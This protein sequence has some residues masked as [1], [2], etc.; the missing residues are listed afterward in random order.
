[1]RFNSGLS[2]LL[3]NFV[4]KTRINST[5]V[6]SGP[7]ILFGSLLVA[8]LT[9][10]T[11]P[12]NS[13][14]GFL[15]LVQTPRILFV[16]KNKIVHY[17][18]EK[19]DSSYIVVVMNNQ[20]IKI[21][22]R[23]AYQKS[24]IEYCKKMR[25]MIVE[26]VNKNPDQ[27]VSR[28]AQIESINIFKY[29]ELQRV[30]MSIQA[31]TGTKN[32]EEKHWS[33]I[34]EKEGLQ[35]FLKRQGHDGLFLLATGNLEGNKANLHAYNS[36]RS[37]KKKL[38]KIMTPVH[39][40]ESE[41]L[42]SQFLSKSIGTPNSPLLVYFSKEGEQNIHQAKIK[43]KKYMLLGIKHQIIHQKQQ[44]AVVV[45]K[46]PKLL[47][48]GMQNDKL[49]GFKNDFQ[50]IYEFLYTETNY[51]NI[52]DS[53]MGSAIHFKKE[54]LKFW[55][56]NSMMME[57]VSI[58]QVDTQ[59]GFQK[60]EDHLSPRIPIIVDP[61]DKNQSIEVFSLA[62]SA[63]SSLRPTLSVNILSSNPEQTMRDIHNL[64]LN[65]PLL[66]DHCL[67]IVFLNS[68]MSHLLPHLNELHSPWTLY[69]LKSQFNSSYRKNFIC[70]PQ[71]LHQDVQELVQQFKNQ[72]NLDV[73]EY[74]WDQFKSL[75][76]LTSKMYKTP[77]Q[78]MTQ[79]C[80]HGNKN[81]SQFLEV[82]KFL[83]ELYSK[84]TKTDMTMMQSP[85]IP[86][87]LDE[88]QLSSVNIV[89]E[90]WNSLDIID[91]KNSTNSEETTGIIPKRVVIQLED[92]D[93]E[94]G[95]DTLRAKIDQFI[96]ENTN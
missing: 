69:D 33:E 46:D 42:F 28:E 27:K 71:S 34:K 37:I 63:N 5:L 58:D 81:S 36:R 22:D 30:R 77:S 15:D 47:D 9:L 32:K 80:L 20:N 62:H 51:M 60:V 90:K 4:L 93:L 10:R 16:P 25:E 29:S 59:S 21:K 38:R 48:L 88:R 91:I 70:S 78:E 26:K 55:A 68:S 1:M 74:Q 18:M 65:F 14:C 56:T 12:A 76:S 31:T 87:F 96:S 19:D 23:T 66:K 75:T 40:L 49:Y 94:K 3:Q 86:Y 54:L 7:K 64:G 43:L 72:E 79:I 35:I 73:V 44:A 2:R 13:K 39:V 84:N 89:L 67:P 6:K 52:Q 41:E 8:G 83:L 61:R 45:L 92:Y 50:D 85:D 53:G 57:G 82:S 11:N 95:K 24:V 17:M